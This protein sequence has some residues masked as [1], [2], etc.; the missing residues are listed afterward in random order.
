MSRHKTSYWR[1]CKFA[2]SIV[3][4]SILFYSIP[5]IV[6]G[7]DEP[8]RV[9]VKISKPFIF[10]EKDG[11]HGFSIDLWEKIAEKRGWTYEYKFYETMPD[12]LA[13]T[14]QN[15]I[16]LANTSLSITSERENYL[17]FSHPTFSS[18]LQILVYDDA[19]SS[20]LW[21]MINLFTTPTMLQALGISALFFVIVSHMIWFL[22]RKSDSTFERAYGRG[23]WESFWWA[24]VTSTTVGY[25][26]KVPQSVLGRILAMIWM[27]IG[28]ILIS[29]LTA[30][31]TTTLTLQELRGTIKGPEDLPGKLVGTLIGTTSSDY[32]RDKGIRF[33]E[34]ETLEEAT[35]ELLEDRVDAIVYDSPILRYLA[36]SP[37][38]QGRVH[39]VGSVFQSEN[40]GIAFPANSPYREEVNNSLL[41]L[42]ENGVYAR[43]HTQW[44]GD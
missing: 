20:P 13:A 14:L 8:R 10:E 32:L 26:D 15:E 23:L 1:Y 18:G 7:Q 12:L 6:V 27:L 35:E 5:E 42:Y 19:S 41:E 43:L 11:L 44:F 31:I 24:F 34:Y 9:G 40:Y 4:I 21:A 25:G 38:G 39:V 17:D 3:A 36:V 29:Y 16:D 22:E 37:E 28:I 33:R 2:I 30:T